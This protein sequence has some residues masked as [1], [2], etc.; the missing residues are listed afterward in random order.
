MLSGL[1][2]AVETGGVEGLWPGQSESGRFARRKGSEFPML[3]G[4]RCPRYPEV[5]LIR[6]RILHRGIDVFL[7][8]PTTLSPA[9]DLCLLW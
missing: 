7:N 3:R 2:G 1:R 5:E 8:L 6:V 4:L 9:P